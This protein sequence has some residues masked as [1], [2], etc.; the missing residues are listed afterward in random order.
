VSAGLIAIIG[1]T[2]KTACPDY[3]VRVRMKTTRVL[4]LH[5]L[6]AARAPAV[7]KFLLRAGMCRLISIQSPRKSNQRDEIRARTRISFVFR[8]KND[9]DDDAALDFTHFMDMTVSLNTL[10]T[11]MIHSSTN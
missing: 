4:K 7:V 9:V 11:L 6:S 1:I 2:Q 3:M 5:V 8:H 10:Q